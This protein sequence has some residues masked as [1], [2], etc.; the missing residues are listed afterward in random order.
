MAIAVVRA[1]SQYAEATSAALTGSLTATFAA[2]YKPSSLTNSA[3]LSCGRSATNDDYYV[4]GMDGTGQGY[5][6]VN[7]GSGSGTAFAA[8]V[9]NGVWA[10]VAG[11]Q[12][13][14]TSRTA[15]VNGAA[16]TPNT[17]NIGAA[18][19]SLDRTTIGALIITGSRLSFSGGDIAECAIWNVALTTA[20]IASLA[21]GASPLVIR[22]ANLV[23]YAPLNVA[24]SPEQD[25]RGSLALTFGAAGAAPSKATSHP[26]I[27]KPSGWLPVG[28]PVTGGGPPPTPTA[29]KRALL[30]V[31]V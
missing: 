14:A 10:H 31:G 22:P 26:R 8:G 23:L 15:Y 20:E 3:I 17:T 25:L 9:S 24:A 13:S 1:S 4:L 6:E 18:P 12:S 29:Q 28:K 11:V 19:A 2:W 27:F 16:G 21:A 30:G 7:G 5:V